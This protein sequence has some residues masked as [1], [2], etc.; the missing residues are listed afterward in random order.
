[1]IYMSKNFKIGK[2]YFCRGNYMDAEI[3]LNYALNTLDV[4]PD[5]GLSKGS[6]KDS[7]SDLEIYIES[8]VLLGIIE[9]NNKYF[10]GAFEH[11]A[12]ALYF[13]SDARLLYNSETA[14]KSM[15]T[16]LRFDSTCGN[17][18]RLKKMINKWIAELPS[19]K[20]IETLC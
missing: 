15:D 1:M 13:K 20:L 18:E 8:H 9:Q 12:A 6:K 16:I 4:D 5:T 11:Y 3:H 7:C 10:Q 2:S 17:N 19:S 14:E